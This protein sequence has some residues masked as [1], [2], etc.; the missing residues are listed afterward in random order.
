MFL[1]WTHMYFAT[2]TALKTRTDTQTT[3][4]GFDHCFLL[5][6]FDGNCL[7]CHQ[8]KANLWSLTHPRFWN[9]TDQSQG[10]WRDVKIPGFQNSHLNVEIRLHFFSKGTD[11]E[12]SRFVLFLS[13]SLR[14]LVFS[15]FQV[16]AFDAV[17][18]NRLQF[19]AFDTKQ[20]P[21]LLEGRDSEGGNPNR[22]SFC[23][24]LLGEY[25]MYTG[26][27]LVWHSSAM[28]CCSWH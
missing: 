10:W 1:F 9:A 6:P 15:N 28:R 2:S 25:R 26:A 17:F 8:T 20:N 19:A 4:L 16:F 21:T 22:A 12:K 7:T 23:T 11:R 5:G 14:C 13:S 18:A 24:S 3:C 27:A